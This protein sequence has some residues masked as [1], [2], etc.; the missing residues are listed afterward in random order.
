MKKPSEKIRKTLWI[1]SLII[2][3]ASLFC[4]TYCTNASC[5]DFGGGFIDLCFG[6]YGALFLGNTYA[7]WFANPFFLTAIFS[8]HKYPIFSF[9]FSIIALLIAL[10]FLKG[11]T[12]LLNEAGHKGYITELQ[13]GYWLWLISM[14]LLVLSLI[15]PIIQVIQDNKRFKKLKNNSL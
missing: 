10:T 15:A 7:V 1:I 5:S 8:S 11:G 2:F 14:I 3:G 6:W 12:V 9:V 4:P 13:L